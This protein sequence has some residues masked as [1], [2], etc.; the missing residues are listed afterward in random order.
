MK[1]NFLYK[2]TAASRT[3]DLGVAAPR[4]PFSALYPQLNFLNPP[5]PPQKK[6]IPGY[7]TESVQL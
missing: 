5:P 6:K 1:W 3:P 4:S 2:I 7:A